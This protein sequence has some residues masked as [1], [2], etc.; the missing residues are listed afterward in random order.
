MQ[1][2]LGNGIGKGTSKIGAGA[3]FKEHVP[4]QS[5][6][7]RFDTRRRLCG[8]GA[9]EAIGERVSNQSKHHRAGSTTST[10]ALNW[11]ICWGETGILYQH[12]PRHVDVLVEMM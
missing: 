7:L 11:R 12:D 5:E 9:Q 3:Q 4:P 2:A 10:K 1:Q 8:V 6:N